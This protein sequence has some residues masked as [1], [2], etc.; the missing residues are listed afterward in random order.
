MSS[1][2]LKVRS[3]SGIATFGSGLPKVHIHPL[4]CP[5]NPLNAYDPPPV[6]DYW[7]YTFLLEG[8]VTRGLSLSHAI[9][10]STLRKIQTHLFGTSSVQTP[11]VYDLPNNTN[12]VWRALLLSPP[13]PPPLIHIPVVA[14]TNEENVPPHEAE[15]T[16]VAAVTSTIN[17][18][19]K[20]NPA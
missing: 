12:K 15:T 11:S 10:K 7:L 18:G 5:P 6:L 19:T 14:A 20:R 16:P 13:M 4:Q 8:T 17:R 3:N 9:L 2:F 1:C